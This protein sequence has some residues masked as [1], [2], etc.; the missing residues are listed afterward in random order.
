MVS[1]LLFYK[2]CERAEQTFSLF[3]VDKKVQ[4]SELAFW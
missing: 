1:F 2:L 3:M 4:M